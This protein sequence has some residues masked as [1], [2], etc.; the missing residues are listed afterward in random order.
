MGEGIS[1]LFLLL[2]PRAFLRKG[3]VG[4]ANACGV[5]QIKGLV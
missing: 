1:R 5:R 2:S 3:L 4:A